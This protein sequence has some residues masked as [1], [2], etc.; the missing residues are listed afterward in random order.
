MFLKYPKQHGPANAKHLPSS[1]VQLFPVCAG[2]AFSHQAYLHGQPLGI[3]L[4][5]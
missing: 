5:Q 2:D 3:P 1:H 4:K